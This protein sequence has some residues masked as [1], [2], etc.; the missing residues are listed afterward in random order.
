M[1]MTKIAQP[2][3]CCNSCGTQFGRWY[4]SG[5][6]ARPHAHLATYHVGRCDVCEL[7]Q[8]EVTEPRDF[9]YLTPGWKKETR[10]ARGR[11]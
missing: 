11:V 5:Y 4:A 10:Y 6:Y 8:V 3:W 9:G 2:S 7:D 1:T